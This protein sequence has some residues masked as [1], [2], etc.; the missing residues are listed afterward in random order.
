MPTVALPNSETRTEIAAAAERWLDAYVRQDAS[1]MGADAA[2]GMSVED[3]RAAGDRPEPGAPGVRRNFERV[4]F[5]FA[6]AG[7][8]MSAR[9]TEHADLAG[10]TRE[11]VS[12][13]SQVWMRDADRWR[14][15]NV[16]LITDPSASR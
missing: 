10:R 8:I 5:Q 4:R 12:L 11:Y 2:D 7:I 13:I 16:R 3:Q 9:V 15:M 1:G 14:L 6:G